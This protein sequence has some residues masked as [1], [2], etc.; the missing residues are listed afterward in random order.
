MTTPRLLRNAKA[1][2][3]NQTEAEQRLWYHLRAH[4]FEGA[5]FKRQ[6]PIG[7]FIVD[8]VCMECRLVVELDGGQ[9]ADEVDY[10][11]RRDAWLAAQGYKVL[12]FWNNQVMRELPAVLE[13]IGEALA[14]AGHA[15]SPPAPLPQVGE[16]RE[17]E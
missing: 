7:P 6:K 8:F 13:R 5:K 1:L 9:H 16:E 3:K 4:R 14:G 17:F 15:P 12:R 10:D 2:R 11:A